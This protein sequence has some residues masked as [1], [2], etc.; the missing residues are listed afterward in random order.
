MIT[1][2]EAW[3]FRCLRHIEQP[4]DRFRILVGG[5][6]S[7]KSTFLSIPRFLRDL[8]NDGAPAAVQALCS[9]QQVDG[10]RE[11]LWQGEGTEFQ[12]AVELAPPE[13]L[14]PWASAPLF[15][16]EVA[17]GVPG[18]AQPRIE[19]E[20]LLLYP[21]G[22]TRQPSAG[23]GQAV[24]FPQPSW[25]PRGILHDELHPRQRGR[26]KVV[27]KKRA[28]GRDYYQWKLPEAL[29]TKDAWNQS[30][31]VGRHRAALALLPGGEDSTQEDPYA[32]SRWVKRLLA[33]R[34]F[35]IQL[36]VDRMRRA[37]PPSERSGF[38]LDG[39]NLPWALIGMREG[40]PERYTQWREHV[41]TALPDLTDIEARVRDDDRH[42]YI[43][44]RYDSGSVVPASLL[45]DGTLRML[46]LTLIAYHAEEPALFL[47]EEPE[48]GVHPRAVEAVYESL[49]SM[50]EHQVLLASHSPVL[51]SLAEPRHIL[52][53]ARD[54]SGASDVVEGERHPALRDWQRTPT[55]ADLNFAGVLG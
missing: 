47:I 51:L 6:A 45:S 8:L 38:A 43:V 9:G 52:C 22:P 1:R 29:R 26:Q 34:V 55:L 44:A 28:S 2:V 18:D 31:T 33:E 3:N 49:S 30:F 21:D 53:F 10:M 37:S 14:I 36:D 13:G 20:A 42:A 32:A 5:N 23:N 11:L 39:S 40:R 50:W 48:N 41:R 7:G 54:G 12:V 24:L 15:R 17:I 16:Y 35:P 25:S 4:L 27:S 46:A 19:A